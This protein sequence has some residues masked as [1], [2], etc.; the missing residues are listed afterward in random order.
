[1]LTALCIDTLTNLSLDAVALSAEEMGNI[2]HLGTPGSKGTAARPGAV[3]ESAC[4]EGVLSYLQGASTTLA[5]VVADNH[6]VVYVR[7]DVGAWR[8]HT[9]ERDMDLALVL[10]GA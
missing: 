8:R 4:P 1:M 9:L 7:D 6:G 3:C 5:E 10:R 2:L